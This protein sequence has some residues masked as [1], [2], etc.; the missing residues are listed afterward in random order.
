MGG[1]KLET[2]RFALMVAFPVA[3][4]WLFNQ[5]SLF[6][7]FVSKKCLLILQHHTQHHYIS[8]KMKGYKVPDSRE[9]DAAIARWKEQLLAQKRKEE[10]EHFLREQMAFEE[11]RRLR[12]QQ[13]A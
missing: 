2:G 11:A 6:K 7:V 9:G 3:A 8:I 4:F 5:P 13:V 1:W 12:E 10:Y